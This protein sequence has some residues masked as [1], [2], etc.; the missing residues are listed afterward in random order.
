LSRDP[1]LYFALGSAYA[2]VGR[3]QDAARARATFQRLNAEEESRSKTGGE[4]EPIGSGKIPAGDV[5][6]LPQ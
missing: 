2:R 6:S 5:P 4:A 1:K 3:Q